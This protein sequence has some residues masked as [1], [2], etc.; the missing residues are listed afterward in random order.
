MCTVAASA[1]AAVA[2]NIPS[3]EQLATI[4]ERASL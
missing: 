3:G 1:F 4:G 2:V